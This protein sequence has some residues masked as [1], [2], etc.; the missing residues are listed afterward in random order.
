M[1]PSRGRLL[2]LFY[3]AKPSEITNN[4]GN[5]AILECNLHERNKLIS[6]SYPIHLEKI[7]EAKFFI[8]KLYIDEYAVIIWR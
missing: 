6:L 3:N 1:H 8:F 2:Q 7:R 4:P 5:M